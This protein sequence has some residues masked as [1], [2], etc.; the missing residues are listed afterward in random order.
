MQ[1]PI[2]YVQ[3]DLPQ[4]KRH[5]VTCCSAERLSR[6]ERLPSELIVGVLLEP[7]EDFTSGVK[8]D[9]FGVNSAFVHFLHQFIGECGP[10]T[11][12]MQMDA[13][14]I[15]NGKLHVI[16]ERSPRPEPGQ[17]WDVWDEDLIGEFEVKDEFIV[18]GSYR[19]NP[20]YRVLSSN[21]QGFMQLEE[22]L[23]RLLVSEF[24]D[25][26]EPEGDF[27]AGDFGLIQ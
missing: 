11:E 1:L 6:R 22:E 16:D 7:T 15:E 21:G 23:M 14:A 17:P 12:K 19:P 3:A 26:P 27:I 13:G 24:N 5:L 25:L 10:L 18:E 2:V 9:N 20:A 8:P 4:G